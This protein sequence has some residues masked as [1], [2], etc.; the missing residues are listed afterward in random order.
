MRRQVPVNSAFHQ[1]HYAGSATHATAAAK[2][3]RPPF[4]PNLILAL[5][6]ASDRGAS[7]LNQAGR[8]TPLAAAAQTLAYGSG[9]ANQMNPPDLWPHRFPAD[10]QEGCS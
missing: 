5:R 4:H 8:A 9:T 3:Q 6:L 7:D 2:R 10:I 1:V